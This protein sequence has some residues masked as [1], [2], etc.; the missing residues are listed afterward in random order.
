MFHLTDPPN[1]DQKTLEKLIESSGVMD[2]H[3]HFLKMTVDKLE[4]GLHPKYQWMTS[5]VINDAR[6]NMAKTLNITL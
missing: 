6:V 4:V 5:D 1:L 2:E 3:T